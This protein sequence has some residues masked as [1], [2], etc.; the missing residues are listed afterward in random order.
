MAICME[1]LGDIGNDI[2]EFIDISNYLGLMKKF[3][4]IPK[5]ARMASVF[6]LKLPTK[7]A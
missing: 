6:S 2:E 5:L 4:A 3:Q 1:N 7:R